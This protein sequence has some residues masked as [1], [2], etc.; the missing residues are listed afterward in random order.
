MP[1][2]TI[3]VTVG[4]VPGKVKFYNRKKKVFDTTEKSVERVILELVEETAQKIKEKTMHPGSVS[5][6]MYDLYYT[7][8]E[9]SDSEYPFLKS[10]N[11]PNPDI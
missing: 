2:K 3:F 8:Y 1:L 9:T 7:A 10:S 11:A 4:W 5:M 6:I